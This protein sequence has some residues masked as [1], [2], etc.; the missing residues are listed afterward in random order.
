MGIWDVITDVF[1]AAKP[2]S[3]VEAEAPAEEK[4]S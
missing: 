3:D 4:V 1:E 2:W